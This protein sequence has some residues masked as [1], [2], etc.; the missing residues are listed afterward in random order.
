[1]EQ[2]EGVSDSTYYVPCLLSVLPNAFKFLGLVAPFAAPLVWPQR[3]LPPIHASLVCL[4][5]GFCFV[6]HSIA[7]RIM[8]S[9]CML[10]EACMSGQAA[11]HHACVRVLVLRDPGLRRFA[12]GWVQAAVADGYSWASGSVA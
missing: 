2:A 12:R 8:Q 11:M 5:L 10:I 7:S 9:L 1:M 3:H 4:S 6:K